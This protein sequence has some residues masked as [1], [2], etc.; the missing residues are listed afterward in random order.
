MAV[1]TAGFIAACVPGAQASQRRYG[2]PASATIAQAILESAWGRSDLATKANNYFS[3]K[4][5]VTPSPHQIGCVDKATW[6]HVDGADITVTAS[7]R[8]YA[9]MA[10]SFLDHG[11]FLTRPRYARGRG[12]VASV[13]GAAMSR[14]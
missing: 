3:I 6:E 7:F 11:L 2:V 1:D 10:D 4:C 9:S 12:A 8:R 13:A 14:R 5:G